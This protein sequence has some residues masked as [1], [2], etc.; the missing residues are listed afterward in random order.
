MIDHCRKHEQ[1]LNKFFKI[2]TYTKIEAWL[3]VSIRGCLDMHGLYEV[4]RD[5]DNRF[6]LIDI[7]TALN[8]LSKPQCPYRNQIYFRCL[9]PSSTN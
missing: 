9:H 1:H 2:L 8:C 6:N 4:L 7:S 5:M 3:P